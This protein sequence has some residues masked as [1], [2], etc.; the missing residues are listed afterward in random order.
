MSKG[1]HREMRRQMTFR[2]KQ[3]QRQAERAAASA[4][5]AV[6]ERA[7]SASP[8]T[9]VPGDTP[10]YHFLSLPHLGLFLHALWARR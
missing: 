9:C 4:G 5:A 7:V 2:I 10:W 3:A 8:P 6:D 1:H